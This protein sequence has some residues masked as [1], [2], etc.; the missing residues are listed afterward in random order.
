MRTS[1]RKRRGGE[2]EKRIGNR[3]DVKEDKD[4]KEGETG[5]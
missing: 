5:I 2:E 3:D 4:E 1:D